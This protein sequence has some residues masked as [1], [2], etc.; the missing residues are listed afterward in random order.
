MKIGIGCDHILERDKSIEMVEALCAIFP[1]AEIYTLAHRPKQVLGPLERKKIHSTFLS[2]KVSSHDELKKYSYLVPTAAKNLHITCSLDIFIDVSSGL[3]HGLKTCKKTKRFSY[4]LDVRGDSGNKG[5]LNKIF[6]AYLESWKKKNLLDNR[7]LWVETL[8][9]E[10]SLKEI[11]RE[12]KVLR[13]FVKIEDFKVI[14]AKGFTHSAFLVNAYSLNSQSAK[15]VAEELKKKNLKF[16]FIGSDEHLSDLK[17][18]LG[19]D[20]FFGEKCHGE[21]AP[22]LSSA[23]GLIDFDKHPYSPIALECLASGRPVLKNGDEESSSELQG[24]I[25][26]ED[27][28]DLFEKLPSLSHESWTDKSEELRRGVVKFNEARFK[29]QVKKFLES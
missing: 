20:I 6:S 29:T 16:K 23:A 14:K 7:T 27:L 5:I 18:A 17:A 22:L 26:F 19:E 28:N 3:S 4:L 10:K 24:L 12:S 13:P 15:K 25:P 1:E 11:G 9:L 2:H 8:E 21:L